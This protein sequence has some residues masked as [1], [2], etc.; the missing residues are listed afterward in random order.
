MPE[1][2]CLQRLARYFRVETT[3]GETTWGLVS[4]KPRLSLLSISL[5][6]T[7]FMVEVNKCTSSNNFNLTGF[8]IGY[9]CKENVFVASVTLLFFQRKVHPYFSFPNA[10]DYACSLPVHSPI[11]FF[12][13]VLQKCGGLAL[14]ILHYSFDRP[15]SAKASLQVQNSDGNLALFFSCCL[16]N[17]KPPK[18]HVDSPKSCV[19]LADYQ[20]VSQCGTLVG[21]W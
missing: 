16:C 1:N 10:S 18:L 19:R 2:E 21:S 3:F 7:Q 17:Q 14:P 11:V 4:V 5:V 6:L 9:I 12:L 20:E 8:T 15:C 13:C